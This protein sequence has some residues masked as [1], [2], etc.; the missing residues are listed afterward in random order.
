MKKNF[1]FTLI[2][3]LVV[4]AIIAILAGLLLPALA[5][6][7]EKAKSANCLSNLRQWGL[8]QHM[9]AT[10]N[11]DGIPRDGMNAGATYGAGDSKDP[12]AWFN[13]LPTFV[14]EKTLESYTLNTTGNSQFNSTVAPFPGG[15]G[16]IWHCPSATMSAADLA[17]LSGNGRDGFFSYVMNIDLK[18]ADATG[19][20][21]PVIPYPKM[22]KMNTLK[23]PTATVLLTDSIF[24]STE[25]FSAGNTF[26]SVN[27]AGRWRAFPK[28]H[29]KTGGILNFMDGHAAS[30]KQSAITN[31]QANGNEALLKDVIWNARYRELNP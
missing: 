2:E 24:N 18:K 14:A 10:E 4:I 25:G 12:N 28:R 17:A 13:L 1:A 9:Y 31:Q 22:P 6:A 3:L 15:R 29:N 8:A 30:F 11:N 20:T 21:G 19:V 27:P 23:K 26:Y 7:K 5:K 16:K